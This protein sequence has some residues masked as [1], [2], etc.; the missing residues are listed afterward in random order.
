MGRRSRKICRWPTALAE[1]ILLQGLL[2]TGGHATDAVPATGAPTNGALITDSSDS[3][4]RLGGT[5]LYLEV[6]LNGV[7]SGLAHFSQLDGDL[8]VSTATLR[9]LGFVLPANTPD[10]VRLNGLPGVR[11]EYDAGQQDVTLS[12]PLRMLKLDMTVLNAPDNSR[13]RATASPGVLLNYDVY[14]TLGQHDS[15][16]L[17]AF[18]ELRAF[19]GS[20]VFSSTALSQAT[21]SGNDWEDHSVRL[22]TSWSTSFP[23]SLVTLR[24]GDT[25]TD[26]LSWSRSTRIAGLQL[27]TNFALQPYLVTAPLPAFLGSATLPS[28]V[29]L[30]VNGVQQYSGKVPAGPF[31]LNTVPNVNGAGNAQ[32]VLTDA[33][34]RATTLNFSLYDEHQLLQQ[35]LSDWSAELGVVREN[36]GLNSFDYGHDP[37]ASGTW[38]YGVSNNFT[39]EAHAEATRGLVNAGGGGAWLLGS[40]GGVVSGSLA[41]SQYDG[42]SGS[43]YALGYSWR[44]DRFNFSV[45]GIRTHGDYSDV[46]TL[47][48]PPPPSISA[49][50]VAGYSTK[51][52]GSFGVSYVHL[53]YPQQDATRYASAYWFKS[54]GRSLSLNLSYNQNLDKSSDRSLFLVATLALDHNVTVSGSMQRDQGHTGF[55]LDA[56]Q[57]P[58]SQ[59][60]FSWRAAVRQGDGQNGGQGELDYLGPYGQLAAGVNA[61]GDARYGYMDANGALVLMGGDLFAAR[62]ISDGF[63]VVSTAGVANVPVKLENN[64]IGTTDSHGML[65]VSPLNA[66][67]NNRLSI[68]PMDLPA[69][70]RIDHVNALATPTDRAGIL[71]RFGIARIRAASII[72]H[73]AN[74]QPLPVGSRASLAGQADHDAMVGFDGTVYLDTLSL[75]NSLIVHTPDGVCRTS[76]DYRTEGKTI[77]TIGPLLCRKDSSP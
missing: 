27:G 74:D 7:H 72:L 54:A 59:G 43:L 65:L 12:A 29:Q 32:V 26:A 70:M 35:G 36:Y 66:Y 46:A 37:A 48:G 15:S 56:S 10:P 9:E 2:A 76:F 4:S 69:D 49:Q 33:L 16:S 40:A 53:R 1:A 61:V 51:Y 5:E 60:G 64:L 24:V 23:D 77:P 6:V 73:D 34:G 28:D 55:V 14:G 17:S 19:N 62:H 38:R 30:Y 52:L 57:S 71:V 13:P 45:D 22:D 3:A 11:A 25:L 63:A 50:A 18:T 44:S 8:W 68:D 58:P 31:Q 39:V 67:Q 75:H 47:Y 21:R 20:G 41:G 42:R